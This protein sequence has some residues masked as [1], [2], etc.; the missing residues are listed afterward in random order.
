MRNRSGKTFSLFPE[1]FSA[2]SIITPLSSHISF[3]YIYLLISKF[4]GLSRS[5]YVYLPA[6]TSDVFLGVGDASA[7]PRRSIQTNS[8]GP[9]DQIRVNTRLGQL[10][11]CITEE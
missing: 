11:F 10:A 8:T 3:H 4:Y 6:S 2:N 5:V 9:N 7:T 1:T